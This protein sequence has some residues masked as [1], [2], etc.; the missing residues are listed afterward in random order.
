MS[1]LGLCLYMKNN[2]T[3]A[4]NI[5]ERALTIKDL[6]YIRF[7]LGMAY[8]ELGRMDLSTIHLQRFLHTAK[9]GYTE[10]RRLA[11]QWLSTE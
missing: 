4:V 6:P 2:P 1:D 10:Q 7:N 11:R 3:G 9:E 5:W 8:R